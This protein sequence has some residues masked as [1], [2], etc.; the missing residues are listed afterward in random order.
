MGKVT[1]QI[2]HTPRK[3]VLHT[4]GKVLSRGSYI[5]NMVESAEPTPG[6]NTNESKQ[7][8]M[9]ALRETT[10]PALSAGDVA[11]EVDFSRRTVHSR[12]KELE[13]VGEVKSDKIGGNMAYW[14]PSPDRMPRRPTE[15]AGGLNK[16]EARAFWVATIG[17]VAGAIAVVA[18]I[19]LWLER[20]EWY[21]KLLGGIHVTE[22]AIS[23][24]AVVFLASIFV[25]LLVIFR[26]YIT[27]LR[28]RVETEATLFWYRR[29]TP[30]KNG[31]EQRIAELRP[32]LKE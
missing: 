1:E 28:R 17:A 4:A 2:L 19:G 15:T 12:L 31:V 16:T 22:T 21:P 14:I 8:V 5:P 10:K 3:V 20:Y 6:P 23:A 24:G 27:F 9:R 25:L 29:I 11:E 30:V 18:G 7:A 26:A 13:D 32:E